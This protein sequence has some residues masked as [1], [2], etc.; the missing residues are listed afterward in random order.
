M[1][2][3]VPYCAITSLKSHQVWWGD[4]FSDIFSFSGLFWVQT[5][6]I[7][8]VFQLSQPWNWWYFDVWW[9]QMFLWMSTTTFH[10][11]LNAVEALWMVE[12]GLGRDFSLQTQFWIGSSKTLIHV[13]D[14]VPTSNSGQ[15]L[16]LMAQN[17][18]LDV[19][20]NFVLMVEHSLT[21]LSGQK[22]QGKAFSPQTQGLWNMVQTCSR[23]C[24]DLKRG[25]I[26]EFDGWNCSFGCKLQL[27][28]YG[29]ML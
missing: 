23:H 13:Q 14:T 6:H 9:L 10:L 27:C 20:S 8:A 16:C 1:Q 3:F 24:P 21:P 11:W 26:F 7:L 18:P 19:D 29:W 17:F 2:F 28:F 15:I 12:N 5:W 25:S 22:R 4:I